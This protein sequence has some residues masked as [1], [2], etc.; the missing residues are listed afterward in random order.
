MLPQ[1][2]NNVQQQLLTITISQWAIGIG[3]ILAI[4]SIIGNSL[5]MTM[6]LTDDV[7]A[8]LVLVFIL[9]GVLSLFFLAAGVIARWLGSRGGIAN[10]IEDQ[11]LRSIAREELGR[12][13]NAMEVMVVKL[14]EEHKTEGFRPETIHRYLE[15][16]G[17][18]PPHEAWEREFLRELTIHLIGLA[19]KIKSASRAIANDPHAHTITIQG[20]EYLPLEIAHLCKKLGRKLASILGTPAP[21]RPVHRTTTPR[22]LLHRKYSDPVSNSPDMS[23]AAD[24]S[25]KPE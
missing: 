15:L 18:V 7:Q 14:R 10:E 9:S 8:L 19:S 2:P 24:I 13:P 12:A 4:L 3:A 6:V 20:R 1:S 5:T 11:A 25:E 17:V 22:S 21:A 23:D 16:R